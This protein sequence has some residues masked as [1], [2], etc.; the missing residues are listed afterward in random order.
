MAGRGTSKEVL[1]GSWDCPVA[2]SF[3]KIGHTVTP[4]A[5]MSRQEALLFIAGKDPRPLLV[6]RECTSCRGTDHAVFNRRLKNETVKLL[7]NWFHCVKLP[8]TVSKPMHAFNRLFTEPGKR[9]KVHL[10]IS[11]RNGKHRIEF[12]GAQ[13]QSVFKKGLASIIDKSY[14]K[15]PKVALKSMLRFL[16]RFDMFDQSEQQILR[17]LDAEAEAHGVKTSKH[18]KLTK[19]IA[20]VRAKKAKSMKNAKAVCDLKLR[21]IDPKAATGATTAAA[22]SK[23]KAD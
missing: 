22:K 23:K 1:A 6:L 10:F 18:K 5:L 9:S 3:H 17:A 4:R 19:K 2:D 20:Q 21:I 8:P 13:P 7:L 11:T 16:S 14:E 15:K 12:D